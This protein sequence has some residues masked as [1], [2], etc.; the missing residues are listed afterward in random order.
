MVK[1]CAIY[2][3]MKPAADNSLCVTDTDRCR[4]GS[5]LATSNALAWGTSR[6]L[7]KVE[8]ILEDAEAVRPRLAPKHLVTMNT[9]VKLVDL[10]SGK[11][12]TVT[13]VYPDDIDLVSNGVSIFES[14]GTALLGCE[15]GDVVECPEKQCHR[16]FRVDEIIYQ[17]EQ[18]GAFYL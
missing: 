3:P 11:P 6:W 10:G 14:L 16:R 18:A 7:A 2:T 12:R 5:L 1:L 4:L 8:A 17:P 13:L 15:V 9:T